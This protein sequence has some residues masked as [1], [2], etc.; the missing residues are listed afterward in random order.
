MGRQV[1]STAHPEPC[2]WEDEHYG[3]GRGASDEGV[4]GT[5]QSSILK[6]AQRTFCYA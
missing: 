1:V 3:E 6:R 5:R 4:V 2:E